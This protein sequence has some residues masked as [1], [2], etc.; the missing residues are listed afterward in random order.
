MNNKS[1]HNYC[2]C[3]YPQ[4]YVEGNITQYYACKKC[5]KAYHGKVLQFPEE[6]VDKARE[7]LKEKFPRYSNKEREKEK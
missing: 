5:N 7:I 4:I 1:D 3:I 6:L 2:V